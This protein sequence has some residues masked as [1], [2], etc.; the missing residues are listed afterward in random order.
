M[1]LSDIL[2]P[3]NNL[4]NSR[5]LEFT[6]IREITKSQEQEEQQQQLS[7]FM[8]R[9]STSRSKIFI[10]PFKT[11]VNEES[12]AISILNGQTAPTPCTTLTRPAGMTSHWFSKLVIIDSVKICSGWYPP[13]IKGVQ[14]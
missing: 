12:I 8:D 10:K 11:P 1:K 5:N 3:E 14:H 6:K 9:D 7:N 2:I 13:T 4:S